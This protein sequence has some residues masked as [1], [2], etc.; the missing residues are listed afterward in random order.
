MLAAIPA[1]TTTLQ[2][3]VGMQNM[4][5]RIQLDRPTPPGSGLLTRALART[6][7]ELATE[8]VTTATLRQLFEVVTRLSHRFQPRL[9][10]LGQVKHP[11]QHDASEFL[12]F[13]LDNLSQDATQQQYPTNV[14]NQLMVIPLP[15]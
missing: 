14:C 13:L 11:Q 10:R 7:A 8:K 2:Q 4:Y 15:H 6:L 5:K 12:H 3:C 1:F 9:N